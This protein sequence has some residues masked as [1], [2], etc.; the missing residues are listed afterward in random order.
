MMINR[1][2]I[3]IHL[4]CT[5]NSV[6]SLSSFDRA[7]DAL[8]RR[9]FVRT[10]SHLADVESQTSDYKRALA[11]KSRVHVVLGNYESAILDSQRCGDFNSISSIEAKRRDYDRAGVAV[12]IQDYGRAYTISTSLLKESPESLHLLLLR[13]KAGMELG[14]YSSARSDSMNALR[15]SRF[16]PEA[17]LILSRSI[18]QDLGN[19][20]LAHINTKF[21]RLVAP[22]YEPCG[23]YARIFG[24]LRKYLESSRLEFD[25]GHFHGS[26][27][28]LRKVLT[29]RHVNVPR[30]LRRHVKHQMCRAYGNAAINNVSNVA[31]FD[32]LDVC[33]DALSELNGESD[34]I[35]PDDAPIAVECRLRIAW[36]WIY[37]HEEIGK[38][39]Y[40]IEYA[41]SISRQHPSSVDSVLKHLHSDVKDRILYVEEEFKRKEKMEG[42]LYV[43][44]HS[45]IHVTTPC[46]NTHM[47]R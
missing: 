35:T 1:F 19:V 4:L 20:T 15:I 14:F 12:A 37:Q 25:L 21:C 23:V 47:F 32:V 43:K 28:S 38:A 9:D 18:F 16:E 17:I 40:E 31:P 2:I 10:I 30:A 45:L 22:D 5:I 27:E 13:A 6:A 42:D 39:K 26:I 41:E 8:R 36:A 34:E 29:Y 3:L 46:F 7:K 44:T 33:E 11:L 24:T